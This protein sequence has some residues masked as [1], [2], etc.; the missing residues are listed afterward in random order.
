MATERELISN[1]RQWFQCSD[2]NFYALTLHIDALTEAQDAASGRLT[3]AEAAVM[4]ERWS[5]ARA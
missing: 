3:V 4:C 5:R 2:G 1:P